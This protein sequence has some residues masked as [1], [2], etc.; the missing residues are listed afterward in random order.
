MNK[1]VLLVIAIIVLVG[2]FSLAAAV[3]SIFDIGLV[4]SY[5]IQSFMNQEFA[6]YTP[7]IRLSG[8][9]CKW[10]GVSVDVGVVAPFVDMNEP[11]AL[12]LVGNA[13]VRY[14]FG[15]VEPYLAVGPAYRMTVGPD[16]FEVEEEVL[17][18]ARVGLD[19]NILPVLGVGVEAQHFINLP[20]LVED[21]DFYADGALAE[22]RVAITVKAKF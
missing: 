11:L 1:K 13:V 21:T 8:Y 17:I 6:A 15:L 14:P 4:N 5:S 16:Y 22:T 12:E 20:L 7:A 19:F 3:P 2:S 10:F 9:L 18:N